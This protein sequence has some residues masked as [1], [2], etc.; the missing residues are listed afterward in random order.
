MNKQ[1]ML[2]L[3]IVLLDAISLGFI[4][5][6]LP[7]LLE[8]LGGN[9][10]SLFGVAMAGYA[11]CQFLC[12]PILG[13]ISDRIGRKPVLTLS[14]IGGLLDFAA[15]AFGTSIWIIICARMIAGCL[16]GNTLLISALIADNT[17]ERIRART[18]GWMFAAFGVGLGI[19][20]LL[21][22]VIADWSAR[23]PFMGAM[24]LSLA[25]LA[26][27]TIGIRTPTSQ[28]PVT[29]SDY[30]F[31]PLVSLRRVAS[32][33]SVWK[34]LA[35][36]SVL[37]ATGGL[38][39]S[40]WPLYGPDKFEWS[41]TTLGASMVVLSLFTFVSQGL[42][43]GW[44][45]DRFGDRVV[46]V[47]GVGADLA[48]MT[49]IAFVTSGWMIFALTPLF[50]IGGMSL[51]TLQ[52]V[53]SKRAGEDEQGAMQ[54]ALASLNSLMLTIVPIVAT[55]VYSQTASVGIGISWL[56]APCIYL[57]SISTLVGIVRDQHERSEAEPVE[58][59][60]GTARDAVMQ[61]PGARRRPSMRREVV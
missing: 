40:L 17:S 13:S 56:L 44:L 58:I 16:S 26:V 14:I 45:A 33:R 60:E 57:I 3:T 61:I 55:V 46:L 4:F 23:A 54:G 52:S 19:G 20:P 39:A 47:A 21:G 51:P 59:T 37:S 30:N 49:C 32:D 34:Y 2:L 1:I 36:Y 5:T 25:S 11:G 31:N 53:I 22:G 24:A 41:A 12:S 48:A 43:L 9:S 27:L 50:A 15:M 7:P 42:L 18:F 6:S 10:V 8:S 28:L 35:F 38:T 29:S